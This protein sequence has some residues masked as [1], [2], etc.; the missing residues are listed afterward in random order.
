MSQLGRCEKI[1]F[2]ISQSLDRK[3]S[4]LER[5]TLRWHFLTCRKCRR[6]KEALIALRRLLHMYREDGEDRI[7]PSA[8]M[9]SEETRQRIKKVLKQRLREKADKK[10][11]GL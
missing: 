5:L 2:L 6:E 11:L 1:I 10:D 7:D 3:L 9:L 4:F 8:E